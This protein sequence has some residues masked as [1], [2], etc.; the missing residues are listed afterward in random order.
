LDGVD[1]V[2][3]DGAESGEMLHTLFLKQVA[4]RREAPAVITP[5]RTLSYGELHGRALGIARRLREAGV[6]PNELVAIVME[7]GWEQIVAALGVLYSGAAYL[8]IE[9]GLP[10]ER[11]QHLLRHGEVRLALTQSH[12]AQGIDWPGD[13]RRVCV[14]EEEE[15]EGE[16][17]EPAQ[18]RDDLAYVI[19][20]SGSTGLP[21]GVMIDHRGAVNTILDINRRY[22][23]TA[24]DRVFALSSLGFDLSVYDVF[25]PLAVGAAIVMPAADEAFDT[26]HWAEVVLRDGVTIW[27]SV[28]AL[29]NLFVEAAESRPKMAGNKLR[30]ALLS[31]DWIPL[32]LPGQIKKLAP[33]AEVISLG[34]A[35]EASIWSI[36][37]PIEK[38]DPAWK[39]IPYGRAMANQS[40]HVLDKALDPCPTWVAGE[41]YIG[42][43]GLAK[44]Y[45]RNPEKTAASFITHPRT[46]ERLYRT[47]DLGRWLPDGNI[48]FLGR[49]DFQVKIQGLRIELEEIETVLAQHPGLSAAVVTARGERDGPKRLVG[50]VV[51][52]NGAPAGEELRDFVLA[53]LPEYM[54]P[55]AFVAIEGLPLTAN[56]KIDRSALPEP[57][58]VKAAKRGVAPRNELEMKLV[59]IW[60]EV[61]GVGEIGVR[62]DFFDLG[63]HSLVGMQILSR[64]GKT[65]DKR[66][67]L[68]TIIQ[69]RNV[70]KL[71]AV[72][73]EAG[74]S[75]AWYSPIPILPRGSRPARGRV[76]VTSDTH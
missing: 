66:L 68:S 60:E 63:G 42:G 39:S 46:G 57:E 28:P 55:L 4:G 59:K 34:G 7:K 50:Y 29:M 6:K 17:G 44:G 67:P 48:E 52:K 20:T 40:F 36:L 72:L 47:G 56:G 24:R 5:W 11:I 45:W 74:A 16:L 41:L 19:Y 23:V 18:T 38:V 8:P 54:V 71:A 75:A 3:G 37:F 12:R 25:G 76:G 35:T 65:F 26:A 31:G 70:E 49:E 21:K 2:D 13:V 62:D 58:Y 69:A 61:L 73:R 27:N 64:I 30:L 43:I 51:P 14:D 10:S 22:G 32:T 33:E 9:A 1:G 53:K 15:L